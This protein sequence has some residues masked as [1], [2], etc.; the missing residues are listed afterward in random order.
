MAEYIGLLQEYTHVLTFYYKYREAESVIQNCKEA[1]QVE[2]QFTGK[3]GR[4]TK[5]QSFDTPQ[6][7][8]NIKETKN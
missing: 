4:K 2:L 3:L 1:L 5:Y 7:I 8:M 6:L